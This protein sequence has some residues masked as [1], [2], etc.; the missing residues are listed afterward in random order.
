LFRVR[1]GEDMSTRSK[2]WPTNK[3]FQIKPA[4]EAF[5]REHPNG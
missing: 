3:A 2:D 1:Y 4:D 5:F